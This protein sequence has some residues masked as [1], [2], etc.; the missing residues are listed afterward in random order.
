VVTF[1]QLQLDAWLAGFLL[2]FLRV[3]ALFVAAPILGHRALPMRARV[4][5]AAAVAVVVAPLLPVAP[6]IALWSPT[7]MA[8]AAQQV[9]IGLALGFCARLMF[10]VFEIAGEMIGLQMGL[11]FA[12]FFSPQGGSET[13]VGSW[14]H[15]V[16]MLLF[17]SMDGHLLLLD[18]LIATFRSLPIAADPVAALRAVNAAQLGSDVFRLAVSLAL[19]ATL[20]ILFVNLVLGFASRV[21]PQLSIFSV[22][23]PIT[24]LV[25]LAALALSVPH[26]QAVLPQAVGAFLAP[27]R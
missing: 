6:G 11:S 20:L 1:S 5:A 7:G 17:I 12:G 19:P 8:L 13:A 24:L 14:L 22:G 25:G 21:A 2:P 23:M 4:A 10:A 26:L 15:T 9:V 16:A 3:L 18:T 27:W